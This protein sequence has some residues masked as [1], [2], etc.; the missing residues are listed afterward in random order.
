MN[1]MNLTYTISSD[2]YDIFRNDTLWITQH[3]P[4]IPNK[5]LSY[6]ENAQAHIAQL[7]EAENTPKEIPLEEL[8][9]ADID[10]ILMVMGE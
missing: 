8:N 6:E 3:E 9:R 4:H 1:A 7:V 2:G 5:K 10:Y